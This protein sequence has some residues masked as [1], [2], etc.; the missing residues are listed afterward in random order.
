MN[1]EDS[2]VVVDGS[3]RIQLYVKLANVSFVLAGLCATATLVLAFL[4]NAYAFITMPGIMLFVVLGFVFFGQESRE[5]DKVMS[6]CNSRP[7]DSNN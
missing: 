7:N 6:F 4:N 1:K 2:D 5:V 3:K